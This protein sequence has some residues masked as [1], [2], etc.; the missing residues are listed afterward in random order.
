MIIT[1]GNED[2]KSLP[3]LGVGLVVLLG[4]GF[5]PGCSGSSSPPACVKVSGK[6]VDAQGKPIPKLDICFFPTENPDWFSVRQTPKRG[7]PAPPPA[8]NYPLAIGDK[9]GKF[10]LRMA[11]NEGAPPG[12][13]RVTLTG[14]S[15]E[16]NQKIPLKYQ[17]FFN[18]ALEVTI[19]NHDVTDL[20]LKIE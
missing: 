13:Y 20:I 2:M 18:S 8:M 14:R 7:L 17:E 1:R 4:L 16:Q 11:E 5:L 10:V 12:K 19:P 6:V 15:K 9:E 3:G